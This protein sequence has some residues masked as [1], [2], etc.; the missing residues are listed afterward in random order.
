[1]NNNLL[2]L[3]NEFI[4]LVNPIYSSEAVICIL[5]HLLTFSEE[6]KLINHSEM[7]H[8]VKDR[9]LFLIIFFELYT[10]YYGEG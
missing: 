6:D 10:K 3:Y 7:S 8:Y 5:R 9:Y 4:D 1:M 2:E